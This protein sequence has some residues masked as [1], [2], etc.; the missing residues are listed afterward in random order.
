[1]TDMY[2]CCDPGRRNALAS[3]GLLVSG[4]DFIEVTQGATTA[5]PT[6]IDIWLVKPLALPAAQLSPAQVEITGGLRFPAPKVS[7]V[8]PLPGPTQVTHYRV[9]LP[10]GQP[11]DFSAYRLAL[12]TG[13]GGP[14]PGFIDPRLS[15]VDFSFKIACPTDFD[16]F[17]PGD[18]R[19]MAGPPEPEFD[20]AARD[21]RGFRSQMLDR[22]ATLVPGFRHDDAADFTVTLVEALAYRADQQSY[23]LDS[24]STE[25]FLDTARASSSL[26]RLS[27]LVDYHPGQGV[28]A[29]VPL[30]FAFTPGA[31]PDGLMLAASTPVLARTPG[32]APVLG[33]ADYGRALTRV[34]SGTP[35]VFETMAPLALW[36]W[37]NQ[38]DFH[39]WSDAECRLARGATA[40]T[41][42][43]TG[44]GNG[45]LQPGDLI[46]MAESRSPTTG[47]PADADPARRHLVRLTSV[48]PVVDVLAT[49]GVALVTVGWA[50]ADALPF[51][52]VLSSRLPGQSAAA[53]GFACARV[54][55]NVMIADHGASTPPPAHLGL[56]PAETEA[57]RP[58]LD[59]PLPEPGLAWRPRL[60]RADV[61]RVAK[62][63]FQGPLWLTAASLMTP[64][65]ALPALSLA[66]DFATWDSRS[67]L[68]ASGRFDRDFVVEI[69]LEGRAQLRFG[70]GVNGLSPAPGSVLVPS[71][72]FGFGSAGL[73]GQDAL[74]HLAVPAGW[75]GAGITVT[76]PLPGQ[77]GANPETMASIR[78][79]APQAFRVQD[80]A[81]TAADYAAAALR[82]PDVA[83]AL[84]VPRWTGA[85]QTIL[86]YIDRRGGLPVD[87]AF[88]AGL[89][90]HMEHFRLMG[91]DIALRPARPAPLDLALRVCARPGELRTSVGRRVRDALRPFGPRDGSPGFFH[92]DRFTFG[93]SLYL[94]A[95]VAATM[96]V[97]GVETVTPLRFQRYGKPDQGT[98]GLGVIRPAEAEVLECA[99]D[100]SFPERGRLALTLG[101]GA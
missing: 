66:D 68:L 32:L 99:D 86:L 16:C 93:T 35:G 85:W 41:L 89:K 42:I 49:A 14:P 69:G 67:D 62:P 38:M 29:R 33:P 72:R 96:A 73:V 83:N 79:R 24:I 17:D 45:P 28:S 64:A 13:P 25:A 1:M 98:L 21:W 74:V 53:P 15:A 95:L 6:V 23:R 58:R 91:F 51:D 11:T 94:S 87:R 80:R 31:L 75:I 101:G 3:S 71:G 57:L 30:A 18:D 12:V 92:P 97:P 88:S 47:D 9:T 44:G 65:G 2:L 22:I 7:L 84:A 34:L 26:A 48:V 52:L 46:L 60:A 56:T 82:H 20:Y 8:D 10:G 4:V 19:P 100:P 77:G 37:R 78:L 43:D 27:R 54:W 70:D 36:S 63:D 90:A 5:D 76:N 50:A 61:A 81:V 40:C 39:T 59:P 55:G